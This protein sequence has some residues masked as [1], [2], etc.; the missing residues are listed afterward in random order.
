MWKG[1]IWHNFYTA[2]YFLN[3]S[4]FSTVLFSFLFYHFFTPLNSFPLRKLEKNNVFWFQFPL[5]FCRAWEPEP[6]GAAWGKN[7][8]PE[9]LGEKS[10]SRSRSRKNKIGFPWLFFLLLGLV[11]P[12][13]WPLPFTS[14][15]SN[16]QILYKDNG[17]DFWWN[18]KKMM[19]GKLDSQY[20]MFN[21]NFKK[22]EL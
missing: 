12:P 14:S 16:S 8:E 5:T 4:I 10:R 2:I 21:P 13:L 18:L 9:P 19:W 22:H 3:K 17:L 6:Q 1:R 15:F 11:F 20:K 7:Q